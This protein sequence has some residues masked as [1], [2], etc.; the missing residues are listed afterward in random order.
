MNTQSDNLPTIVAITTGVAFALVSVVIAMNTNVK[1]NEPRAA[2]TT[3][4]SQATSTSILQLFNYDVVPDTDTEATTTSP[5]SNGNRCSQQ[6]LNT[7]L[8]TGDRGPAVRDL[9]EFLNADPD[10]RISQSGSGSPGEETNYYGLQ[11]AQAVISFQEK[12]LGSIE[13]EAGVWGLQER[14]QAR[15]VCEDMPTDTTNDDT[16]VNDSQTNTGQQDAPEP[17]TQSSDQVDNQEPATDTENNFSN[18]Q[19]L[20]ENLSDDDRFAD[21]ITNRDR[22]FGG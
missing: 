13:R 1:A 5:S 21:R 16:A 7:N 20:E 3:T 19:Q 18:Y 15:A 17:D 8:E 2:A 4:D 11:T 12:Y 22:L 6:I 10:T 9:Q 14:M